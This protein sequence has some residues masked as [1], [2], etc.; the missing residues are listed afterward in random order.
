MSLP[1]LLAGVERTGPL[2]LDRHLA[3]HGPLPAGGAALIEAVR[4]SGLRGRGGAGFPTAT[5]LEAV[6][7]GRGPR[8]VLVNAAEGDPASAKDRMLLAASPHLVIDGALLAAGAVGARR[9]VVAVP[10]G[11]GAAL[12][13]VRFAVRERGAERRV[14]VVAVP[15][16]YLAGEESALIRHLEGGP[17]KPTVV[18]PRPAERG[19]RRRPTLV[20]NPE[21]LAHLALIA[22]HGPAW[23]RELGPAEHPG[24]ALLTVSG[25][26]ARSGVHEIVLGT[27]FEN[28]L[29]A[30]GGPSERLR[31][32]LVG[33]Y[34]GAWIDATAV[35]A[36]TLDDPALRTH[37]TRLGAGIVLAL[38]E[39]ACP[40]QELSQGVAWLAAQSAR[41]CGPCSNGLPGLA[42][43]MAAL[44]AGTPQRGTH[45]LLERWQGDLVGRGACHLPDGAVRF[46]SSGLRVFADEVAHHERHGSCAACRRPTTLPVPRTAQSAAA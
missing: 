5:K 22:R 31:A 33:G 8:A 36:L 30:A 4:A 45:G 29:A 39:R 37:G 2:S 34:H 28:V 3:V 42:R 14:R 10:D 16:A 11:A 7:G 32:V 35:S 25:A 15:T 26:V 18:P 13:A 23:F 24:S 1:R 12:E 43:L 19:L 17:L 6:A 38:G 20:Q 41:Q 9:V 27:P 21:T 44:V 40:A 46:L